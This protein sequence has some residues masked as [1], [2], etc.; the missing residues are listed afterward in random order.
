MSITITNNYNNIP[1]VYTGN[2]KDNV[3]QTESDGTVRFDRELAKAAYAGQPSFGTAMTGEELYQSL[4]AK[5]EQNKKLY[6]KTEA[7]WIKEQC[8]NWQNMKFKFA[9]ESKLYGYYEFIEKLDKLSE[10][11]RKK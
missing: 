6:G 1:I 7:D 8:P 5:L 4:D 9:G 2:T 3:L 10:E 11:N